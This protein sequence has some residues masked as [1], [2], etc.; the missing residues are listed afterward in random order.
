MSKVGGALPSW[1]WPAG[2]PRRAPVPQQ[3]LDRLLQRL[4]STVKERA[5][6]LTRERALTYGELLEEVLAVAGGM[7]KFD[8]PAIAVMERS[9][10]EALLLLMAGWFAGKQVFLADPG[11]P[12]QRL[13][14]HLQEAK[15]PVA[16]T[17]TDPG[18][19]GGIADVRIVR[20]EELAGPFREIARFRRATEP[21]V[22]IPSAKGV[23]IHSHF[24]LSSMC[25]SL[26]VFIPQL[27]QLPFVCVTPLW[28]WEALLGAFAALLNG[29]PVVFTTFAELEAGQHPPLGNDGY[30]IL[31]RR[32]VDALVRTRYIPP[33]LSKLRYVFVSTGYFTVRWRRQLEALW[34]K[35]ILPIWGSPEVGPAV[36]AH[37][38]WFPLQSH[39]FPLVNVSLVPV[40]PATGKISIVP[41]EMLECAEVGVETLSAMVG[42]T[43]PARSAAVRIGKV[44]RTYRIASVDHVGAV[45]FH[46]PS[47]E[48][49]ES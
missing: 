10:G 21:A 3:P 23:V 19:A 41:W 34:G 40:N 16:L 20:K 36:A 48:E 1:Y 33:L 37:P 8:P 30:T 29:M 49:G 14:A 35:G 27:R 45:T 5:A 44:L 22:L 11:T 39:G 6:I 38:T 46:G 43:E 47:E 7:Q 28:C 2:V 31:R 42:Y 12:A 17:A 24:S 18:E 26:T 25:T 32:E 15:A 13:A 4:S 9:A